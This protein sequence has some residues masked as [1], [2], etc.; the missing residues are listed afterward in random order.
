MGTSWLKATLEVETDV[1]NFL[2]YD[3]R[4]EISFEHF[5]RTFLDKAI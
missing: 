4:F 2:I 5:E 1:P 3:L